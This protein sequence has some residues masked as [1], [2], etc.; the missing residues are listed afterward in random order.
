LGVRGEMY[1]G[2]LQRAV[3][4]V[5][6]WPS[7]WADLATVFAYMEGRWKGGGAECCL[8]AI[9]DLR[10]EPHRRKVLCDLRG[11]KLHVVDDGVAGWV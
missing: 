5:T 11:G 7:L 2:T 6:V 8:H 10:G 1:A 9:V 3:C 4:V